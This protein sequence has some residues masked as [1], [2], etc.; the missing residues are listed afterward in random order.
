MERHVGKYD[1]HRHWI[2]F[3]HDFFNPASVEEN[4]REAEI[5]AAAI[6]YQLDF[7]T[8]IYQEKDSRTAHD[9]TL[10]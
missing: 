3:H 6:T 1:N 2:C 5:M 7:L 10:D 9:Q 4:E 8:A